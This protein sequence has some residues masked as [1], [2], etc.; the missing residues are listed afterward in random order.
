MPP[1]LIP[2]TPFYD[3]VHNAQLENFSKNTYSD[4][5][6]SL[7]SIVHGIN[8]NVLQV[9]NALNNMPIPQDKTML[10]ALMTGLSEAVDAKDLAFEHV[11]DN[12]S[13][14]MT[15]AKKAGIDYKIIIKP[16]SKDFIKESQNIKSDQKSIS[17]FI[18]GP[19][20][21]QLSSVISSVISQA[22]AQNNSSF[23]PYITNLKNLQELIQYSP[24]NHAQA[25]SSNNV[26][27]ECGPGSPC[28]FMFYLFTNVS[29]RNIDTAI[30]GVASGIWMVKNGYGANIP[31]PMVTIS[32]PSTNKVAPV[33][34]QMPQMM[35]RF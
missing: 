14:V 24:S 28:D 23:G 4:V 7:Q 16:L 5:V 10:A 20:K 17:D 12:G 21:S 2:G 3:Q 25:G 19:L 8:F 6:K 32:P 33:L 18:N 35:F 9:N 13:K 29:S 22:N 34:Q 11:Y 1:P 31:P 15:T 27:Y 26:R 30:G